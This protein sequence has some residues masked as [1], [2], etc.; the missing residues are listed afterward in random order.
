VTK[1]RRSTPRR[2][3]T[4]IAITKPVSAQCRLSDEAD[5]DAE[6]EQALPRCPDELTECL[7]DLWWKQAL[8]RLRRWRQPP[9]SAHS[10]TRDRPRSLERYSLIA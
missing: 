9:P 3:S 7:L 4:Q 1:G 8:D 6:R 2:G 5:A 10:R